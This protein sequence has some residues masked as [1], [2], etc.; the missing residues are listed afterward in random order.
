[1]TVDG[2]DYLLEKPLRAD[3]ALVHAHE[4]DWQGNL[5][6]SLTA[7]NFNPIICM[8]ADTVIVDAETIV[9]VGVITPD[10]VKTPGIL[11]DH[12]LQRVA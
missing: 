11:V 5:R 1:M 2:E 9:P 12:I 3:F 4:A 6:Y 7:H 8:A 10:S